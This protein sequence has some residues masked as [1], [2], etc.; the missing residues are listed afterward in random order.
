MNPLHAHSK[1][2]VLCRHAVRVLGLLALSILGAQAAVTGDP[3]EPDDTPVQ[4]TAIWSVDPS[5]LPP[6]LP[7]PLQ[8][9]DIPQ[10]HT[11]HDAQDQDWL[12]FQ[13]AGNDWHE[14]HVWPQNPALDLRIDL[15]DEQGVLLGT[16]D[17]NFAGESEVLSY[18]LQGP[19]QPLWVRITALNDQDGGPPQG[20]QVAVFQPYLEFDGFLYGTVKD[21]ATGTALVKAGITSPRGQ[22]V[23]T[24]ARGAYMMPHVAGQFDFTATTLGV[25]NPVTQRATIWPLAYTTLD[26]QLFL[27]SSPPPPPSPPPPSPP[28]A[29]KYEQQI[30]TLYIG[31]FGRPPSPNGFDYYSGRMTQTGGN[32]LILMDD[33]F[34]SSESQGLFGALGNSDKVNRV[35]NYLF[36]RNAATGGLSYWTGL[37][38]SGQISLAEMAYTIAYNAAAADRGV[39]AAKRNAAQAFLA[40]LRNRPGCALEVGFARDFLSQVRSSADANRA[41]AGMEATLASMCP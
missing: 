1:F 24:N 21:S 4:S 40:A 22:G 5:T 31:Y 19:S 26:F 30:Y 3:Y 8:D 38:D 7:D 18:Y 34:R 37:I 39:L 15:Y 32:Y 13:A 35:F 17:W 23:L 36:G 12:V 10:V 25:S 29:T 33:F 41:I 14:V 28:P 16:A 2:S 11:I 27:T 6:G 9:L 20:Y